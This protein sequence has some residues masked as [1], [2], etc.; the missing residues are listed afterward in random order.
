[1]IAGELDAASPPADGRFLSS[2]IVGAHYIE[3]AAAHM[4]NI[5]A[6]EIF[7]KAVIGFLIDEGGAAV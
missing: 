7:T 1:M 4:T 2:E 5:E 6:A 3:L